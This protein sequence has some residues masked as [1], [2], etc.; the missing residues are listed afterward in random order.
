MHQCSLSGDLHYIGL[1]AICQKMQECLHAKVWTWVINVQLSIYQAM[2]Q[3][4][5]GI[6]GLY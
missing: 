1:S 6:S 3:G 5:D 2:Q 4:F